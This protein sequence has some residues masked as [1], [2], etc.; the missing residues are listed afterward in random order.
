MFRTT[1]RLL[2]ASAVATTVLLAPGLP[3]QAGA[4]VSLDSEPTGNRLVPEFTFGPAGEEP[5]CDSPVV[6]IYFDEGAA[7]ELDPDDVIEFDSPLSGTFA[8]G[9]APAGFYE[10]EII[11]EDGEFTE[12]FFASFAFARL[13]IDKVV[14]GTAPA[15]TTFTVEALCDDSEGEGD[16]GG[17]FTEE[18]T[19]EASG[20]S[21][22][23]V[24]Y[25]GAVCT[26]TETDDGGA[27]SST[28]TDGT[29]DFLPAPVD[30]T[31]TVTNVFA[32]STPTP[33]PTPPGAA[34]PVVAAPSFTG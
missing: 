32:A 11:C 24:L 34:Q 28:I 33:T 5:V 22:A 14:E 1:A 18:R 2:A 4:G 27:T 15:G 20:G 10:L 12:T 17:A 9:A 29:S 31:S 19:F 3:A 6:T 7:S 13:T 26:V 16:E 23:V 25:S 8:P 21:A 30:L